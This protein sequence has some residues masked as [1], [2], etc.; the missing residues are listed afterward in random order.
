MRPVLSKYLP[1]AGNPQV[2]VDMWIEEADAV[3]L[4]RL[5]EVGG[6][7]R[8]ADVGTTYVEKEYAARA[9]E[10][11]LSWP[12]EGEREARRFQV[13]AS[14][15]DQE[16]AAAAFLLTE[17]ETEVRQAHADHQLAVRVLG[18]YVRREPLAKLKYWIGLPVLWLGDTAGVW[19]AAVINGDIVAIAAGQALSAGLSAVCAGLVGAEFKHRQLARGRQRDPKSLSTDERRY[20]RLFSENDSGKGI[21][22]LVSLLSLTVVL[23][24]AGGI[25]VLRSSIEGS[26]SG[27]TFGLLAAATAIASGLLGYATADEVADLLATTA[28]HVRRSEQRH[29]HLAA[30]AAPKARASALEA[31]RSIQAEYQLRGQ[32]AGKRMESLSWRV[33]R[34][35]PQVMGHGFPTGEQSGVIGRRPRR[36]IPS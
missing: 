28:K 26:A 31:A 24:L 21:V 10:Q 20:Q 13:E 27:F 16:A 3:S 32:A 6:H 33:L 14:G 8:P 34:R 25:G 19:S 30:A 12:A 35:N 11:E 23:L 7:A 29:L 2:A 1:R 36:G 18:P 9:D 15:L 22:K 5:D 4:P 17:S